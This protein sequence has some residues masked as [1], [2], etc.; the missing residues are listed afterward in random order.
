MG[1]EAL[2]GSNFTQT[3]YKNKV[4]RMTPQKKFSNWTD[5]N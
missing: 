1:E 5:K 2:F 4:S 3:V